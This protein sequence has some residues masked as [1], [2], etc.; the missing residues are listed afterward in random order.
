MYIIYIYNIYNI[1]IIYIYYIY[2][3]M[4]IYIYQQL[5]TTDNH[6]TVLH[7]SNYQMVFY[8]IYI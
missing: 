8:N 6:D 3:Y 7:V 4:Y 1:Y 5:T 2:M